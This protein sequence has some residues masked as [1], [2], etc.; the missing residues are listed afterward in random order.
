MSRQSMPPPP[1]PT[2]VIAAPGEAPDHE[3]QALWFA[4]AR[5]RLT[6]VVLVPA[7]QG[8]S[9]A[10]IADSLVDTGRRLVDSPVTAIVA[11]VV[12]HDFVARTAALLASTHRR[13][14]APGASTLEVVVA[15]G[16]VTVEPLGLALVQAADGVVLCIEKGRTRI[17]AARRSVE[18][19]GRERIVGCVTFR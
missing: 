18:L 11:D 5:R 19:V 4:L 16:P 10:E 6:S 7:D 17:A 14:P 1:A 12:S 9:V 3:H 2:V 13:E 8:R 15:I